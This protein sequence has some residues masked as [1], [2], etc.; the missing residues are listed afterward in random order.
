MK[1]HQKVSKRKGFFIFRIYNNRIFSLAN[2]ILSTFTGILF[3][4]ILFL[5]KPHMVINMIVFLYY[6]L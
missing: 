6:I 5:M 2:E 1:T 3:L 4:I